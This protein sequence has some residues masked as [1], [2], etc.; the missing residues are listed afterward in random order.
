MRVRFG[1]HEQQAI[2]AL[3]HGDHVCGRL[4]AFGGTSWN[5]TTEVWTLRGLVRYHTLFVM[6]LAKR[7]VQIAHISCQMNGKVM[8]QVAR[9]LTDSEDGFLNDMS[10]FVCDNDTLFTNDF[11]ETG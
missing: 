6:N 7:Q 8:A 4:V 10:Y 2:C 3:S 9:K 5:L 1:R 11:C